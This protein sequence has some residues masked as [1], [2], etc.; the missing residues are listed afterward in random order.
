MVELSLL[1]RPRD[2]EAGVPLPRLQYLP[3]G[4][5]GCEIGMAREQVLQRWGVK[6]PVTTGDGA[7]VLNPKPPQ[8]FDAIL[9]WFDRDRV[10][11]VIARRGGVPGSGGPQQMASAMSEWWGREIRQLGWPGRQDFTP[12]NVLHSMAWLDETT[13]VRQFWQEKDDGTSHIFM[14]WRDIPTP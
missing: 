8:P 6:K 2:Q 14:E 5:E 12:H 11:R 1:D 9:V 13:R 7:L 4:P 3:R 10:S